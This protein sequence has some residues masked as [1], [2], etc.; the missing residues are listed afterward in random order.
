MSSNHPTPYTTRSSDGTVHTV[1]KIL[2][3]GQILA[4]FEGPYNQIHAEVFNADGTP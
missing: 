2:D 4:T 1:H 3:G